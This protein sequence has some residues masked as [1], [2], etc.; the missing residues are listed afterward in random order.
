MRSGIRSIGVTLLLVW[1]AFAR[2]A[3]AADLI[4]G[5]RTE[6]A[7][8]DPHFLWSG[9]ST[10]FFYHYL[11][12]V[13]RTGADGKLVPGIAKSWRATDAHTWVFDL[14]PR[15]KFADGTPITPDDLIASY[16]R[17]I[18]M[19]NGSYRG[20]FSLVDH[21]EASGP[22]QLTVTTKSPNPYLP[23]S[24]AQVAVLPKKIA[25][26]AQS[27]D[28]FDA[29]ANVSAGPYLFE[30]YKPGDRLVLKRNPGYWGKPARWDTV[31]FRFLPDGAA[32]VAAL[33][34]GSVD[35]ID[36]VLPDDV[37]RIKSHPEL[38]VV[39]KPGDRAVFMTYDLSRDVTPQ[40]TDASGKP[41]DPNPFRDVRVRKALALAVNREAIIARVLDGQGAPM[42]QL[43]SPLLG[44]YD[45]SIKPV[46]YDPAQAKA[47]L[48]AAGYPNGF[49]LTLSCFNGRLVNDARVCQAVGQMLQRIGLK[50]TVDVEP[51]PVLVSKTTC[52]CARM[53]SLFMATW[54]SAY[55]GEVGAGLANVIRSYDRKAGKATWNL[56]EYSNPAVDKLID[57]ATETID[58]QTRHQ[59]SAEAMKAAMADFPEL[60]LH[61]EA[62]T[63][64][65][66]KTLMPEP[67]FNEYTDAD[68]ILPAGSH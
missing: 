4:I 32:R 38:R 57:G 55:A 40:V 39:S 34:S 20:L 66:K 26:T 48:K 43:G 44:G 51:Y 1:L 36:G 14:D 19:P 18:H 46:P 5:S 68:H 3:S 21:M 11:G 28:F 15:A 22:L 9:A 33:L 61:L 24:L 54:S 65:S 8:M 25:D 53:P 42:T 6:P 17:A 37:A 27:K 49:S 23:F 56:G 2:A 41:L 35:V 29:K 58:P 12:F 10:Q 50:V 52:H 47:L 60:P 30:S 45:P 13:A 16:R 31:T 59:L 63:L 62:V 7:S 67:L 64:A